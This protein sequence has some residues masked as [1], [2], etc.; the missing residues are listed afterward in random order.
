[1]FKFLSFL[2]FCSFFLISE[3]RELILP[4]TPVFTHEDTES[5]ISVQLPALDE[6]DRE[7]SLWRAQCQKGDCLGGLSRSAC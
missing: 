5:A 1:M 6:N 7:F 3:G 4:Q 2:F